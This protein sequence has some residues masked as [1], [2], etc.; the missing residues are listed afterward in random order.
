MPL[1]SPHTHLRQHTDKSLFNHAQDYQ[2]SLCFS[3]SPRITYER[4]R[5]VCIARVVDTNI[6]PWLAETHFL[7]LPHNLVLIPLGP[8]EAMQVCFGR[9]HGMRKQTPESKANSSIGKDISALVERG[10]ER[11]F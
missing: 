3:P 9:L 1:Y 2:C 11:I 8:Q 7:I 4:W 6:T 10:I 5:K